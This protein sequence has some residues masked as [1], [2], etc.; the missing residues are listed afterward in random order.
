MTRKVHSNDIH[1]KQGHTGEDRMLAT[2]NHPHYSIKGTLEVCEYCAK[3][4]TKKKL[5]LK[6]AE[7]RDLKPRKMIYIF[8]SSEKKPSYGGSKNWVLMQDSDTKQN[9]FFFTKKE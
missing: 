6:V 8:I 9:W 3:S 4:K 2:A 1:A 5:L 7:E